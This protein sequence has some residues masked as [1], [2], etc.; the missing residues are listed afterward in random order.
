[1]SLRDTTID[2]N[3]EVLVQL[4]CHDQRRDR[5]ISGAYKPE[6][7][8]DPGILSERRIVASDWRARRGDLTFDGCRAGRE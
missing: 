5:C 7:E 4:G 2:E 3:D 8:S 6:K 1:M